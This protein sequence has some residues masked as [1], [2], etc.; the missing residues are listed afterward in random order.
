MVTQVL[1]SCQNGGGALCCEL[2]HRKIKK[3]LCVYL[4]QPGILAYEGGV[5]NI[6]QSRT[7]L[8]VPPTIELRIF[9][10]FF[11]LPII[12]KVPSSDSR[13]HRKR[14]TNGLSN[15]R[16]KP[17]IRM[18]TIFFGKI[19]CT[20]TGHWPRLL[21]RITFFVFLCVRWNWNQFSCHFDCDR[22][23]A[24]T[25][26]THKNENK[27]SFEWENSPITILRLLYMDFVI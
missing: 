24:H 2:W 10:Y 4:R 5:G 6:L 14:I 15:T 18:R 20:F 27:N 8:F 1:I 25:P 3:K 12:I 11:S 19:V 22:S 26:H 16:K 17:I 21:S 9:S 23:A 13:L 7:L